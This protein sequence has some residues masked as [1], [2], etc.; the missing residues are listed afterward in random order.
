L[1]AILTGGAGKGYTFLKFRFK[2]FHFATGKPGEAAFHLKNACASGRKVF[3]N[4]LGAKL[5]H[6]FSISWILT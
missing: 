2:V 3:E 4:A 1:L 5:I 6:A